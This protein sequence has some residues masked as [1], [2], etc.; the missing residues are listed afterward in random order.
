METTV[1]A[2]APTPA[3]VVSTN[4]KVAS[5]ASTT[6]IAPSTI[7]QHKD[8]HQSDTNM[9]ISIPL[10]NVANTNMVH[11]D[12][13]GKNVAD[14]TIPSAAATAPI[15][16]VPAHVHANIPASAPPAHVPQHHT[17]APVSNMISDPYERR[18]QMTHAAPVLMQHH[19]PAERTIHCSYSW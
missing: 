1:P 17:S 11:I 10:G 7:E 9:D 4:E 8:K 3:P 16:Y 2:A 12:P 19:P 6:E 14:V 13:T 18:R 5:T 15:S